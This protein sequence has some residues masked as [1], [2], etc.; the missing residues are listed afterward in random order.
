M[1]SVAGSGFVRFLGALG[2]W[3]W[4]I[5]AGLNGVTQL[6][7][8]VAF[9]GTLSGRLAEDFEKRQGLLPHC[10]G[11]TPLCL[12]AD[13]SSFNLEVFRRDE[14]VAIILVG[15]R[16]AHP[17]DCGQQGFVVGELERPSETYVVAHSVTPIECRVAPLPRVRDNDL[18][19]A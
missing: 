19:V 16:V 6:A 17:V 8:E 1:R 3:R 10:R 9:D 14:A 2:L 13:A 7:L 18:S 11:T 15:N 5:A 12:Y 4:A